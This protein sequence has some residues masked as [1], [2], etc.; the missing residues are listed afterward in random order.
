M[1]CAEFQKVLPYIIETGGSADEES[2]LGSCPVCSDLVS[3]LKYIAEQAKL[4]LPMHDP[5]L[6]VWER[7]QRSLSAEGL[8]KPGRMPQLLRVGQPS[9]R[10]WPALAAAGAIAAVVI[11]GL[12]V[13]VWQRGDTSHQ[14][15]SSTPAAAN[16]SIDRD[17]SKLLAEVE[18][19]EPRL[20]P[21]YEKNLENVNAY[22]RDARRSVA[23]DPNDEE[24]R[25]YLMQA[26]S[27]KALL[28]EMAVSHSLQ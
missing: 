23:Q 9:A 4:L 3:D 20:R 17:D 8:I 11:L 6:G 1:T 5:S 15:A 12:A 25:E 10:S 16:P 27:Q 14:T 24:A 18:K 21:V 26:Y 7:L 28:Y 19:R 2:H 13:L 22:I